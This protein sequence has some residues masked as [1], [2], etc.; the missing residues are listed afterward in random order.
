MGT[1]AQLQTD[2]MVLCD[3]VYYQTPESMKLVY[4]CIRYTRN[5]LKTSHAD[6][7]PYKLL[8]GYSLTVMYTDPDD[9]LT[10]KVAM[11]QTASLETSYKSNNIYHDVYNIY[12]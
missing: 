6:N 3:N 12:Y 7:N 8:K 4:P 2:L 11:I 5:K 10:D 1:R 9:D